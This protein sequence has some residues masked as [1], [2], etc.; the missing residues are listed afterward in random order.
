[1]RL[2]HLEDEARGDGGVESIAAGLEDRHAC[3]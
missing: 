1:M 2:D 3:R